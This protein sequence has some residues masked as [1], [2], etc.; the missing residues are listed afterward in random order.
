MLAVVA[1]G[2]F[3][4]LAQLGHEIDRFGA[5]HLDIDVE[6]LA[7]PLDRVEALDL[8]LDAAGQGDAELTIGRRHWLLWLPCADVRPQDSDY[9]TG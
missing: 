9:T 5:A 3:H 4:R 2:D 7:E 6:Q 1:D 8:S